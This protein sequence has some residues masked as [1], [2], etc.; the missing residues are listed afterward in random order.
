VE[1]KKIIQL[2][3]VRHIPSRREPRK[4]IMKKLARERPKKWEI[5]AKLL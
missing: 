4:L 1:S 3:H 2:G 5:I